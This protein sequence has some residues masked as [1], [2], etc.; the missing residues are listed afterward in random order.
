MYYKLLTDNELKILE[1]V[2]NKTGTDYEIKNNLLPNDNFMSVIEDLLCEV[3][4]LEEQ[5]ETLE[6]DKRDNYDSRK[7]SE[8]TGDSYDDR[9]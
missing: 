1:I 7:M 2:S 6:N 8:Y 5:I 4:R 3:G 9:F